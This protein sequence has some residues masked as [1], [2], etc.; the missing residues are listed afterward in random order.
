M[1]SP[2]AIKRTSNGQYANLPVGNCGRCGNY[3]YTQVERRFSSSHPSMHCHSPLGNRTIPLRASRKLFKKSDREYADR[4][5]RGIFIQSARHCHSDTDLCRA[6]SGKRRKRRCERCGACGK[7]GNSLDQSAAHQRNPFHRQGASLNRH[8][9]ALS[10]LWLC[11]LLFSFFALTIGAEEAESETVGEEIPVEFGD[12]LN[13]LPPEIAELLP[14]E[15]FSQDSGEVN[16]AV[17]EMSSFSYLV[18]CFFA[19]VGLHWEDCLRLLL[20][21]AGLLLLSSVFSAA[22]AAI[23]SEALG[24]AFSLCASLAMLTAILVQGYG[25]VE[26]VA[27]YFSNLNKL[28]STAIPLIGVLY[29]MG[30]NVT[31][32]AASAGGLTVFMTVLEEV[33][34]RSILPFCGICLAFSMMASLDGG[35]R[36]GTLLATLKKQYTTLLTFLMML[37]LA[38]IGAQTTLGAR[39]DT[40]AMRS[41]KFATGNLIPVVGGSVGELLRTVSAGVGYLRGTVGIC[42]VLLLLLMLMPTLV[43]LLLYRFVWQLGASL[44]DMLGCETEKKLLDE[45]ASLSGYLIAAVSI[46]STV[47]LLALTLLAHCAS[48]IG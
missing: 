26:G 36:M 14:A 24:R 34:G 8:L 18:R 25:M 29:A 9:K 13:S 31:A 12:L 17:S 28:T 47:L 40:L 22:R 30:G 41:A 45:I 46:C 20:T 16:G 39:A 3:R 15:L 19:A 4:G 44:A 35:V 32:A 48:A 10:I 2:R 6:L 27:A 43:Q 37:L 21:I 33:V 38:M 23:K 42:G 1:I 5:I 11:L 7:G